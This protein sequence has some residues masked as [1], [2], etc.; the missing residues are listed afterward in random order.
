M[1]GAF[2]I[3]VLNDT[4]KGQEL[5]DH[6]E[7]IEETQQR[8]KGFKC[9]EMDG[10]CDTPPAVTSDDMNMFSDDNGL[11]TISGERHSMCQVI[12]VNPLFCQIFGYR[13][14]DLIGG[15]VNKIIPNPFGPIHDAVVS[16]YLDTGFAKV[17]DRV[18]QVLGINGDGYLFQFVLCVKHIV[19]PEGRQSFVGIVKPGK[20]LTNSGFALMDNTFT[21]LHATQNVCQVLGMRP[22]STKD[23]EVKKLYPNINH[24]RLIDKQGMKTIWTTG[25]QKY[26]I[27]WFGDALPLAGTVCYICR[28]K[29]KVKVEG[30]RSAVSSVSSVA[31]ANP[32]VFSPHG[33]TEQLK[34]DGHMSESID[35]GYRASIDGGGGGCPFVPSASLNRPNI[36]TRS[37]FGGCPVMGSKSDRPNTA[38]D[39]QGLA[40]N[41]A[42]LR[43]NSISINLPNNSDSR[44]SELPSA[45][46]QPYRRVS[47]FRDEVRGHPQ[48][49]PDMPVMPK[50]VTPL[51][52]AMKK[53][54]GNKEDPTRRSSASSTRSVKNKYETQLRVTVAKKN[55]QINSRLGIVH[56]SFQI[57]FVIIIGMAIYTNLQFNYIFSSAVS[58]LVRLEDHCILTSD[59]VTMF[60]AVRT[61][62]IYRF[63]QNSPYLQLGINVT[64]AKQI[65]HNKFQNLKRNR[66]KMLNLYGNLVN[67]SAPVRQKYRVIDSLEVL[68]SLNAISEYTATSP[69]SDIVYSP[70]MMYVLT[71]G[72]TIGLDLM[73]KSTTLALKEY[74]DF[75]TSQGNWVIVL[76]AIAPILAAIQLLILFPVHYMIELKRKEFLKMFYDIPKQVVKGIYQA[77]LQ[78]MIDSA[79]DKSGSDGDS[80]E[81]MNNLLNMEGVGSS[82][83]L[84]DKSVYRGQNGEVKEPFNLI[85]AHR[86]YMFDKRGIGLKCWM[87]LAVSCVYF[88]TSGYQVQNY[89]NNNQLTG[90][91]LYWSGQRLIMM[92][93]ASFWLREGYIYSIVTKNASVDIDL[94]NTPLWNS[95]ITDFTWTDFGLIY[96]DPVM[97][98][99]PITKMSFTDPQV[100]LEL[101]NACVDTLPADCST[102]WSGLMTRGLH[103]VINKYVLQAGLIFNMVTQMIDP[104][105]PMPKAQDYQTLNTMLSQIRQLDTDYMTPTFY[106]SMSYFTASPESQVQ[107][108]QTFH[109]TFTV[110]VVV[111]LVLYYL[112][113]IRALVRY[114]MS[115]MRQ[116]SGLV[117]MLPAEVLMSIP[118]FKKWSAAIDGSTTTGTKQEPSIKG[119]EVMSASTPS[120][121]MGQLL[122][123][124]TGLS[125]APTSKSPGSFL[126][127]SFGR[128]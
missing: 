17:I 38:S 119:S 69:F 54:T 116:T 43:D 53:H 8:E 36:D 106:Q 82:E 5:L 46:P 127:Y 61:I 19:D 124:Q 128:I 122:A 90:N 52:G 85:R 9:E 102:Y 13:K 126:T 104:K 30:A 65:V 33:S 88:I 113:V 45:P 7:E 87:I 35:A 22:R 91:T 44:P 67:I 99:T 11:I 121:G 28:I 40:V 77:R 31:E 18:R 49:P 120:P 21:I 20:T 57:L 27:E 123:H 73:N 50:A 48:P 34:R 63:S 97:N 56:A 117:Y 47:N 76:S 112:I 96:G 62:D 42:N 12:S 95:L 83:S 86:R 68:F 108:F 37:S 70:R 103:S 6:A 89:I 51:S 1:Y 78:R 92:K 98:N 64:D 16:A 55:S 60:D 111:A 32:L 29:F 114:M 100:L 94:I 23:F 15:N 75:I 118:S 105:T 79:G 72:P 14:H 3:N 59:M 80:D 84:N 10:D 125:L 109:L 25:G 66:M 2:L 4:K 41:T 107:W 74:N 101:N 58:A 71:N 24:E 115:E 81:E 39:H 110:C 93:R 26:D